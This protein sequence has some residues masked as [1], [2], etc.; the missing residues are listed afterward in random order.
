M[1]QQRQ[2][3]SWILKTIVLP[4]LLLALLGTL[5]AH[6][7]RPQEQHLV[8]LG[9]SDI[10]SD[11]YGYIYEE[12]RESPNGG[13]A[14][15]YSYIEEVRSANPGTTVLIDNGDSFQGNILSDSIYSRD[16]DSIHPMSKFY[17]QARYDALVLGNHE[18]NFGLDFISRINEELNCPVLA[19]NTSYH[20]MPLAASDKKAPLASAYTVVERQGIRIGILGLTNPNIPRWE[21]DKVDS[22][23]FQGIAETA[24]KY[25]AILRDEEAC[26]LVLV[27]VHDGL[28]PEYSE[29]GRENGVVAM[30]KQV[31][32]I[33]MVL[34]GH[35]HESIAKRI[36]GV[37]VGMPVS[38]GRQMVRFD[39][40]LTKQTG[41]WQPTDIQVSLVDMAKIK[42]SF[43]LRKL[44]QKDHQRTLDFIYGDSLSRANESAGVLAYATAD[45]QPMNEIRAL[46]AARL[47][48]TA[49]LDLLA[50]VQL[51]LS[52]ADVTS[53]ALFKD[54]ARIVKGPID[55]ATFFNFYKFD[56]Y[57]Y[58]VEL[59][60]R[61]LKTYMEWSAAYYNSW[62]P[63]DITISFNKDRPG[64][65]YDV[66]EGVDYE[67]DLSQPPGK[68]IKNVRYADKALRDDQVLTLAVNDYRY[69]ATLKAQNLI[70]EKYNWKSPLSIREHLAQYLEEQGEISPEVNHN[71]RIVGV[72]LEHSLRAD[73]IDLVNQGYLAI[74]YNQSLNIA[75]LEETGVIVGGRVQKP[76]RKVN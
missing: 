48:D 75:E 45:F 6:L 2:Q 49:L 12:D 52:G 40:D 17:N 54:S 19:A 68:R 23:L 20:D 34:L 21:G 41:K 46:P 9:S 64:Y 39:V 43:E 56:N 18:F 29:D 47:E 73:I 24:A 31:E 38:Y 22:L 51:E 74:P 72:D 7:T 57:L 63:G 70:S 13:A 69:S 60:G 35:K 1:R 71:W 14:R 32:G 10:H 30:L 58:T 28:G 62:Q 3:G 5:F 76:A 8:L 66:F 26:D 4:L 61:E 16:P 65:L 50:K 53:V 15:L 33:D 25:V 44:V 11:V 27:A 37:A 67:I 55:Y 42:P 59:T 36:Q